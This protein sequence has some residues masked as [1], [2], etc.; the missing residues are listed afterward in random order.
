MR[1]D[2]IRSVQVDQLVI[3]AALHIARIAVISA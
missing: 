3:I 1:P 2:D